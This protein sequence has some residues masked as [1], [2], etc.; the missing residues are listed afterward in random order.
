MQMQ[1]LK[2]TYEPSQCQLSLRSRHNH[3][4]YHESID[5]TYISWHYSSLRHTICGICKV[6]VEDNIRIA[7]H[8][9]LLCKHSNW[10]SVHGLLSDSAFSVSGPLAWI[11]LPVAL[12]L[13][14]LCHFALFLSGLKTKLLERAWAGSATLRGRYIKLL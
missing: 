10:S 5:I 1:M 11:G 2:T 8:C 7:S 3:D 6:G 12:R 9:A 13:T 4:D 14:P